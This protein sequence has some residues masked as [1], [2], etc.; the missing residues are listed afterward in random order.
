MSVLT[1]RLGALVASSALAASGLAAF[2]A[3]AG[4]I[5]PVTPASNGANW[6]VGQLTGG[7]M[8]N[9]N[10]GG[11]D[12]YGLTIDTGLAL[13]AV[14]GH[15]SDVKTI[16]NALAANIDS[17]VTGGA[18]DEPGSLY[19]GAAAK[20]AYFAE[21]AYLADGTNPSPVAYGGRSLLT[22]VENSVSGTAPIKGR[23]QNVSSFADFSNTIGQAF[24]VNVLS[25][26]SSAK[27]ADALAF[28]LK[29]Q[30]AGG[31]FRLNFTA[32]TTATDQTCDGGVATGQSAPDP[33]VTATALRLL[34]PQVD[35]NAKVARA[36][37]KAEAWLLDQQ[38]ADG[39]FN[40]GTSTNVPN[41]NSTGLAG[42]A[43]GLLGD[44]DA[45]SRAA[46]WVRQHQADELPGCSSH[47]STQTG[48]IAYDNHG[49][50]AGRAGGITDATS[51]QWRR[52]TSQALAV[53]QW[54][55]TGTSAVALTGPS[56]YVEAGK[57]AT[58]HVSGV[59]P[60]HTVCVTGIAI[61]FVGS[62]GIDG[63]AAVSVTIPPGTAT[64]TISATDG[65]TSA[66]VQTKSLGA[67]LLHVKSAAG[68]VRR[69]HTVRITVTGLAAGERVTVRLRGHVVA[70]GTATS[71]GAFSRVI[72][73]GRVLG[74]AT[75]AASGQFADL[76]H[77]SMTIRVIR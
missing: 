37:G 76:R 1:R 73:V 17:Y 5:V 66:A 19:A 22:D 43:L 47:L 24:A 41:A 12:D 16:D 59:V 44:T 56:G 45:A 29:Q 61:A 52:A 9:P 15:A 25:T 58:Y 18:F 60:G 46:V 32:D 53:L 75:L 2:A 38:H 34:L 39:S 63:T 69:G 65:T 30:C 14:G 13:Q 62:A 55:P 51:D 67:A 26:V 35:S 48:A 72:H 23:I 54:A 33:D 6:L 7:L 31:Y 4:A 50:A 21:Q 20:A 74:K 3:P 42:W 27:T 40:G 68:K 57:K 8:H 28:L 10:F 70:S 49:L 11:F 77:G 71:G 64:R 36:I